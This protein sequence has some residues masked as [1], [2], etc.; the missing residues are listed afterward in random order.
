MS[1]TKTKIMIAE[2]HK[3]NDGLKGFNKVVTEYN[4]IVNTIQSGLKVD[5]IDTIRKYI[6]QISISSNP[7]NDSL[8]RILEVLAEIKRTELDDASNRLTEAFGIEVDC[9][10]LFRD[11]EKTVANENS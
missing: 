4:D 8:D 9:A 5:K 6:N 1:R 3:L 11:K 10:K 7:A 2:I